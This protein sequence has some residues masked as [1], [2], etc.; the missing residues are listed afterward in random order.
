MTAPISIVLGYAQ[1]LSLDKK[2]ATASLSSEPTGIGGAYEDSFGALVSAIY[3]W[4]VEAMRQDR[5]FLESFASSSQRVELRRFLNNVQNQRHDKEHNGFDRAA[6]AETWRAQAIA[7][8]A[9][10]AEPDAQMRDALV[11]ELQGALM[12]LCGLARRAAQDP[13]LAGLWRERLATTP[14]AE[15]RNVYSNLGLYPPSSIGH[16]VRQYEGHPRLR[17]AR[18]ASDRAQ[19]AQTVVIGIGLTPLSMAYDELLDDFD[20]LGQSSARSLLILAYGV[21]A[22]GHS[23]ATTVSILK[24][25]WPTV[26]TTV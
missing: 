5:E 20:L 10:E 8:G 24:S 25:I 22:S 21:E 17:S 26:R 7:S 4:Y 16:V 1:R 13:R 9:P 23:N 19:I 14:E 3:R 11:A 15:I 18:S 12:I 2:M 6:D